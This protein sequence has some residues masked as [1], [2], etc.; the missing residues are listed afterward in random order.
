M[1]AMLAALSLAVIHLIVLLR[2]IRLGRPQA[3][4]IG[5]G[6]LLAAFW[7]WALLEGNIWPAVAMT[8][9]TAV[10]GGTVHLAWLVNARYLPSDDWPRARLTGRELRLRVIELLENIMSERATARDFR[11]DADEI[12]ARVD[13]YLK[14]LRDPDNWKR[15]TSMAQ[16]KEAVG[17]K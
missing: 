5:A 2:K 7:L 4:T 10:G 16:A 14:M 9:I 13:W 1:S 15:E 8:A 12:D 11:Q 17:Q 6:V 3:Y